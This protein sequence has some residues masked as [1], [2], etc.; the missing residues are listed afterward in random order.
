MNFF[1]LL[2]FLPFYFCLLLYLSVFRP[3]VVPVCSHETSTL[4]HEMKLDRRKVKKKCDLTCAGATLSHKM[5]V[6]RQTRLRFY[7]CGSNPSHEMRVDRPRLGNKAILTPPGHLSQ[8]IRVDR[9]RLR[10]NC[11]FTPPGHL[12]HEMTVDRQNGN[13]VKARVKTLLGSY[14][15]A[16][17]SKLWKK[18][19][20]LVGRWSGKVC[21]A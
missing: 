13:Q 1:S 8:E 10:K 2:F 21:W 17:I 11:N 14:W 19:R 6:D 18:L 7:F 16:S 3:R 5:K 12:S 4:S 15:P 20:W 9:P